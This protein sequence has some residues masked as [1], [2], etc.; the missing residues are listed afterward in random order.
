MEFFPKKLTREETQKM[1]ERLQMIFDESGYRVYKWNGNIE[2]MTDSIQ[3]T[4]IRKPYTDIYERHTIIVMT[5]PKL[6]FVM[7]H[8]N[9]YVAL[10]L[11]NKYKRK[12]IK[13]YIQ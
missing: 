10:A 6:S 8:P 11:H 3:G 7:I 2:T 12:I 13:F 9:G 4:I 1:V 5:D